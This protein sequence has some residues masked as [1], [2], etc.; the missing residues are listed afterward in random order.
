MSCEREKKC[1]YALEVQEQGRNMQNIS[2]RWIETI[3]IAPTTR[4]S[5][6]RIDITFKYFVGSWIEWFMLFL[7][8]WCTVPNWVCVQ[9]IGID[10]GVKIIAVMI[11]KS[12]IGLAV[13]NRA[14]ALDWDG[15]ERPDYVR[16]GELYPCNCKQYYLYYWYCPCG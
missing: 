7:L 5:S 14:I 12:N 2:M 11:F 9:R 13:L 8:L 3:K 6:G 16:T 4:Q 15:D 10:T 1:V